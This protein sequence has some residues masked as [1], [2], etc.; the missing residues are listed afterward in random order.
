MEIIDSMA[1]VD[2]RVRASVGGTPRRSTVSV[3]VMPSRRLRSEEHTSEL[4]SRQYIVCRLLLEKKKLCI[5]DADTQPLIATL[6]VLQKARKLRDQLIVCTYFARSAPETS[7]L[8][9]PNPHRLSAI[10]ITC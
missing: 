3:S 7:F 8:T 4:Q 9:S 6:I 1:F 2:L 10:G 5:A